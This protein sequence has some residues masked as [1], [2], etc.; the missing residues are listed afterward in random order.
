MASLPLLFN[1]FDLRPQRL[2][3]PS[4][5][6]AQEPFVSRHGFLVARLPLG[7]D[8]SDLRARLLDLLPGGVVVFLPLPSLISEAGVSLCKVLLVL[9]DLGG[10]ASLPFRLKR[11]SLSLPAGV[12]FGRLLKG[13]IQ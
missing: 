4:F 7:S 6:F 8:A 2:G 11:L 9:L 10:V 13:P 5:L 3:R 1:A 12:P